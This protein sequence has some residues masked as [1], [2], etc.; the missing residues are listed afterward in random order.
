MVPHSGIGGC[1][2]MPRKPSA[3]AVWMM[4]LMSSVT[5]TITLDRHSGMMWRSMIRKLPAP[6]SR[7]AA[8]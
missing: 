2:P 7:T 3:A 8:M 6:V 4:P 1:A 5:R